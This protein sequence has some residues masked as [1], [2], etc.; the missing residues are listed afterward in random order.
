VTLVYGYTFNN[1]NE[2]FKGLA[3][4]A[5]QASKQVIDAVDAFLKDLG[6][7]A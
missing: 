4:T 6:P 3:K 5:L 7:E 2:I 1:C